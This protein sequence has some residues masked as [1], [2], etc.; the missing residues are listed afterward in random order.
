MKPFSPRPRY[1]IFLLVFL[2]SGLSSR[3]APAIELSPAERE[4]L[5]EKGEIVFARSGREERRI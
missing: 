4:Y 2:L 5:E 1:R 3:S